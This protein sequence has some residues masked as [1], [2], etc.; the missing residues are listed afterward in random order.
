[1]RSRPR[2]VSRRRRCRGSSSTPSRS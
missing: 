2:A 1:L